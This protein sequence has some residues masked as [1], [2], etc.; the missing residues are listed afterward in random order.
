MENSFFS[1]LVYDEEH[2]CQLYFLT[3][4]C[5]MSLAFYGEKHQIVESLPSPLSCMSLAFY[6]EKHR[7]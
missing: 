7:A 4:R 3:F 1:F 6:G 2:L 5:C